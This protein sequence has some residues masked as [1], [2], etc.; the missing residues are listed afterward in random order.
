[1]PGGNKNIRPEDRTNGFEK[2]PQNINRKG[3][4]RKVSI[5][6]ELEK[7]LQADGTLVFRGN[8]II[9]FGKEP[10]GTQ[11]VKIKLPTQEALAHK[12]I[13]IA[14]GSNKY[15]NTLRALI[16]LLEQFDGKP[17][18]NINANIETEKEE[19]TEEEKKKEINRL[20]KRLK[21]EQK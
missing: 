5:K 21:S 11:Y 2:N 20:L 18:Q 16:Q 1:M 7:L 6:R 19:F 3:A 9:D 12:M 13:S 17:N 14:M 4:P 10:D 8:Q 15:S